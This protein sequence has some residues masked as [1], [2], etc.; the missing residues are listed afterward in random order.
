VRVLVSIPHVSGGADGRHFVGGSSADGV[1]H[2]TLDFIDDVAGDSV[3]VDTVGGAVSR[4][5]I[6]KC[7]EPNSAV[8]MEQP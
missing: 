3:I 1:I 6:F 5:D 4:E 8:R 7:P 2:F